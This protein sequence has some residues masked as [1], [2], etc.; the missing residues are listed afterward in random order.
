MIQKGTRVSNQT[1]TKLV[2]D[3]LLFG[4]FLIAMDPRSSGISVHE[5][6]ATSLFGVLIV[7]LLLSW[8]WIVQVTRRFIGKIH[9]QS[10]I[11]YI[12]NGLLFIDGTVIM[13]SGFMIS[14]A[15][16]PSLG[17]QLPRNFAWRG[18]HE[19]ST[20]LFLVLLGLHTAFHWSWVVN[21]FKRYV[22]QPIG[23]VFSAASR[24]E[25]VA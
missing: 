16:L 7:H 1:K 8:D 23:H 19:L 13:L 22:F 3:L 4:A 21:A 2:V 10:R 20:N 15:V 18:L 14:Q 9:T 25:I 17:I 12:L 5:W 24:K 6:L 11:N